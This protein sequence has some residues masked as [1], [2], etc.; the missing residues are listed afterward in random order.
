[1]TADLS[2]EEIA[3]RAAENERITKEANDL[4]YRARMED[5]ARG[6]RPVMTE[7]AESVLRKLEQQ[8]PKEDSY[9]GGNG[10]EG[11]SEGNS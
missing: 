5:Q 1:M 9:E 4:A 2:P 6:Q 3:A 7:V 8:F 11:N 10:G